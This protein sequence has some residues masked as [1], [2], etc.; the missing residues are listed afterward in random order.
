MIDLYIYHNNLKKNKRYK[1]SMIYKSWVKIK[2][3]RQ[4]QKMQNL[5]K[6][7]KYFKKTLKICKW[8]NKIYKTRF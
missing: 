7:F 4:N 2:I 1:K 3:N 6:S 5:K 8:K